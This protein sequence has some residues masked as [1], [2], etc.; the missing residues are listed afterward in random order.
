MK[1]SRAMLF[2]LLIL[3]TGSTAA[4]TSAASGYSHCFAPS[5]FTG[6]AGLVSDLKWRANCV[7]QNLVTM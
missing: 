7:F 1:V 6:V 3:A 2:S 4:S 5:E